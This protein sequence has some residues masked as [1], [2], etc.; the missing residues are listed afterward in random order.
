M[1]LGGYLKGIM[2]G[3]EKKEKRKKENCQFYAI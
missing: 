3:G 2:G 1:I